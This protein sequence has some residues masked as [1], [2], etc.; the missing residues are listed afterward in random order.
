ME[1]IVKARELCFAQHLKCLDNERYI[2]KFFLYSVSPILTGVR[3]SALICFR[4]CCRNAWYKLK[5]KLCSATGLNAAELH[6]GRC[7]FSVLVYDNRLLFDHI[8]NPN[9]QN[10][11]AR[12]GYPSGK[13]LSEFLLHLKSRF[14]GDKYPHEIG[15]F[16]G[17]PPDD[18]NSFIE[19]GGRNFLCCKYWKVYH[20]KQRAMETFTFI[21]EA[22]SL[23]ISLLTQQI[24][25]NAVA[26]ILKAK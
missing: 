12:N 6:D 15:V 10:I 11:L 13:C 16:L 1:H 2:E 14:S 18:V 19:T 3:P 22:R 21:D 9:A 23:A 5:R 20:N 8:E 24:P 26:K 17:Y 25:I 4:H 7:S